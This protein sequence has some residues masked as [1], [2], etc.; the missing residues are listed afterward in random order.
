MATR[1]PKRKKDDMAQAVSIQ[2]SQELDDMIRRAAQVNET[3]Y[4]AVVR[5]LITGRKLD[6]SR[7]SER[8]W[9]A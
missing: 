3:T 2:L 8:K 9:R 5:K 1:K 7:W 6:L 4:A